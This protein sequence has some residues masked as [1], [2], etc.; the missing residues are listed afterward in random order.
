MKK[1]FFVLLTFISLGLFVGCTSILERSVASSYELLDNYEKLTYSWLCKKG[2]IPE[3]VIAEYYDEPSSLGELGAGLEGPTWII[4]IQIDNTKDFVYGERYDTNGVAKY[5]NNI[6]K[7]IS[8][9]YSNDPAEPEHFVKNW[10]Y[11]VSSIGEIAGITYRLGTIALNYSYV[12]GEWSIISQEPVVNDITNQDSTNTNSKETFYGS[13]ATILLTQEKIVNLLKEKGFYVNYPKVE[14][15]SLD[16]GQHAYYVALELISKKTWDVYSDDLEFRKE[17]EVEI[18]SSLS[19]E[20]KKETY[21]D[22]YFIGVLA[23][24]WDGMRKDMVYL[25]FYPTLGWK[26]YIRNLDD[27]DYSY[28]VPL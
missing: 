15:M 1:C 25:E 19:D 8:S 18:I 12:T 20:L 7:I 16:S 24:T 11:E 21:I 10:V 27:L 13:E 22:Y 17:I 5:L 2:Y 9:L 28:S 26:V 3:S 6:A 14:F 23:S 4:R